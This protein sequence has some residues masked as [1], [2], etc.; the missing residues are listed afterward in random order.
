MKA[1][2]PKIKLIKEALIT[3]GSVNVLTLAKDLSVSEVSIRK[4]LSELEKQQFCIRTHGGA[5]L[6]QQVSRA[7]DVLAFDQNKA[8]IA[9]LAASLI[10][11]GARIILDSGTTT[12]QMLPFLQK[13]PNLVVMTNSLP[14]ATAL[15][16]YSKNATVLMCGGTWDPMSQSFQGQMSEKMIASY[17]FEMAFVG[18]SGIDLAQGTTTF[19]ELTKLSQVMSAVSE[20]TIVLAESNK[21]SKKMP[22]L[23]LPWANISTLVTDNLINEDAVHQIEQ[24]GVVVRTTSQKEK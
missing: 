16:E 10:P 23:E 20:Q 18:A 3:N 21:L 11:A 24:K 17:N 12:A 1:T 19:H 8:D 14:V 6:V 15:T 22:N 5:V 9:A 2:N 13:I 7:N 4:Y